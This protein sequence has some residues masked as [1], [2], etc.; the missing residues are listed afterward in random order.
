MAEKDLISVRELARSFERSRGHVHKL[1]KRLRIDIVEQ[2]GNHT[3]GQKA[4][5]IRRGDLPK[6]QDA[7]RPV[8][9]TK[10]ADQETP[11]GVGSFYLISLEPELDPGRFKLGFGT[12]V[13]ERLRS[14]RVSAPFARI[15]KTWP[16]KNVWEKTA[17]DCIAQGCDRL[18]TEVFRTPDVEQVVARADRF[19]GLMPDVTGPER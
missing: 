7:L 13:S 8:D 3:R 5:Y 4:H 19:F 15:I 6:L 14:H 17:I 11:Y 2:R 18:R 16:C 1:V 10:R 12:D 9:H